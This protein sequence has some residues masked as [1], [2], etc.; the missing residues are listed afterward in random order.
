Y[1]DACES[2]D[3]HTAVAKLCWPHLGWTN[4]TEGDKEIAER[5]FYRDR[6]SYRY[7]S[8]RL[9]HGTNYGGRPNTMSTQTKI[10]IS[11]ILDFQAKYFK[12]FKG[13]KAWHEWVEQQLRSLGYLVSFMGRKRYFF[14]RRDDE[15]VIR[16]AI[17]YDPQGSL[18]DIVNQGML[19]VWKAND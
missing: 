7:M 8:K 12:A 16:H 1:L 11:V 19:R 2:D 10:D 6:Y 17:A 9:G 14:G 3:L 5:P 18:S 13:H 4:S 15:E